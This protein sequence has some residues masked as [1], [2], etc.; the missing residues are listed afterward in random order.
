MKKLLHLLLTGMLCLLFSFAVTGQANME[1]VVYL[2]NG[3]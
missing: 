2:K 3:N 1:D